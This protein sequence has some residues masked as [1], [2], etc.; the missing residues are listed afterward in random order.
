MKL[1]LIIAQPQIFSTSESHDNDLQLPILLTECTAV[2]LS[3]TI[4]KCVFLILLH[5]L[6][7]PKTL[8]FNSKTLICNSVSSYVKLPFVEETP[9]TAPQ[10]NLDESIISVSSL[11]PFEIT[12][13]TVETLS[14][15]PYMS[16]YPAEDMIS[17]L[18]KLPFLNFKT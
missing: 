14:S 1:F 13:K 15:H 7:K 12:L 10:S 3:V 9:K 2:V 8:V 18:S 16:S 4:F 6:Y 17:F 11:L 5:K